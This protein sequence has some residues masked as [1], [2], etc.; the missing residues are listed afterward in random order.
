MREEWEKNE[1]R[2]EE[3]LLYSFGF[4]YFLI[5][6][7]YLFR[8]LG[9]FL[10]RNTFSSSSFEVLRPS[11]DLFL[12]L[13]KKFGS[14]R[15][16]STTSKPR[17][18]H[19]ALASPFLLFGAWFSIVQNRRCESCCACCLQTVDKEG[20]GERDRRFV[21][22]MSSFAFPSPFFWAQIPTLWVRKDKK[23]ALQT[24]PTFVD[25]AS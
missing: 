6:N 15:K 23:L 8:Y 16:R 13:F 4:V 3:E 11:E 2:I 20:L 5:P 17:R 1:R 21:Y 7:F 10:I 24:I 9:F 19:I 14:T 22:C 25:K 18:F 12:Q